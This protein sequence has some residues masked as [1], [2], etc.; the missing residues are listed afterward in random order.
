MKF[1]QGNQLCAHILIIEC[2]VN[3]MNVFFF[4]PLSQIDHLYNYHKVI[5]QWQIQRIQFIFSNF[6]CK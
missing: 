1:M 4:I 3:F 6:I 5:E 2:I